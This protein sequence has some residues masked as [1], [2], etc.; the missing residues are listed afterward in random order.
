MGRV[1]DVLEKIGTTFRLTDTA[2]QGRSERISR[3]HVGD[4]VKL[5]RQ[6]QNRQDPNTIV[7]KNQEGSLG[8]LPPRVTKDLAPL[9]DEKKLLYKAKISRILP[10]TGAD[11]K[12]KTLSV[13]VDVSF[14]VRGEIPGTV[15]TQPKAAQ[16][17]KMRNFSEKMVK[18]LQEEEVVEKMP[19]RSESIEKSQRKEASYDNTKDAEGTDMVQANF[20]K[21]GS[22]EQKKRHRMQ[23]EDLQDGL[24]NEPM[25]D[26][27]LQDELHN[28]PVQ[29]EDIQ[30][31]LQNESIE[32]EDYLE[33]DEPFLSETRE[34]GEQEEELSDNEIMLRGI[35]K[36]RK[37]W[38]EELEEYKQQLQILSKLQFIQ[39][40]K[41]NAEIALVKR[42]L[43]GL[44]MQEKSLQ[45]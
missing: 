19:E 8:V 28:K 22:S 11:G 2:V 41:L 25:E 30:D 37:L 44:D 35:A 21:K 24:Q 38:E 36:E 31:E 34:Y 16:T 6:P 26:E 40:R 39:R 1:E 43:K 29:E 13:T 42:Q 3:I 10:V 32:D 45:T 20:E 5:V 23:E 15:R 4:S 33:E 17:A 12:K 27:D 7:V 9:F 14:K 18:P